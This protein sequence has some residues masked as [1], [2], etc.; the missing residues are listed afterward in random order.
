MKRHLWLLAALLLCGSLTAAP[1]TT[2]GADKLATKAGPPPPGVEAA[3]AL[4]TLTGVAIS[5]LLGVGAVGAVK[6]FR[7]PAEQ[8]GRLAWFA[9]P[10][11][12]GPAL[13][14]VS[15]VF[16]KDA[17]GPAMPTALKK[18]LDVL[19][20]F[21]NKLSALLALGLF[22]PVVASVFHAVGEEGQLSG[23]GLGMI[24]L[25]PLYNLLI[26][27]VALAAFVVVFLA[28]HAINVLILI[29]PFATVDAALKTFRLVLLSTV[30]ATALAN[31]YVGAAWS[32]VLI[33]LSYFIAA[34]SLRMSVFGSVFAW[35]WV[36]LGRRRFHLNPATNWAFTARKLGRTPVRTYGTVTR[37]E[38]GRLVFRYRPWL[39]FP[40]RSL[41]LPAGDYFV[42][43]GL[44]Y[45]EVHRAEG[46]AS[47]AELT[48]PPR[49]RTH[50][51]EFSRIY[52]LGPARDIGLRRGLRNLWRWLTSMVRPRPKAIAAQ[53][54]AGA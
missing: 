11:F 33:G 22:V 42:G 20:L 51:E 49:C 54:P 2:G 25:A 10:W 9:Q 47:V 53:A 27:P 13:F 45:P 50:E 28:S 40:M 15:L 14:L 32:V 16:L 35:D 37:D 12:W 46:E 52:G 29:S 48:L 19:E 34:W 4:S 26:L 44:F 31:P 17:L 30:T 18:P 23:L 38:A 24:E 43:R 7:T 3:Q 5:P 21:E 41:T 39:I 36:T 8:R 1:V 6:Y